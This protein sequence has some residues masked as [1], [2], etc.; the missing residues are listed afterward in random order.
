MLIGTDPMREFRGTFVKEIAGIA[1]EMPEFALIRKRLR[2]AALNSLK[3]GS[4]TR[5][6]GAQASV[7]DILSHVQSTLGRSPFFGP[8]FQVALP[9]ASWKAKKV[10]VAF[11]PKMPGALRGRCLGW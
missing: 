3:N 8:T 9:S 10:E 1:Q 6:D 5:S 11:L 7:H 4:G 2:T